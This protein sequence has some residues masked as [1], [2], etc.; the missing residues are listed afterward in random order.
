MKHVKRAISLFLALVLALALAVPAMAANTLPSLSRSNYIK[1]Y[2]IKS[3]GKIY[4]YTDQSLRTQKS[5]WIG[6]SYD[7]CRIVNISGDAVQVLYPLDTGGWISQPQWFKRSDFTAT[8]ISGAITYETITKQITTYRRADGKQQYGY[9]GQN[10]KV[11]I[12]GS[13]GSYTQIIYPLTGG[14][15]KMAWAKTSELNNARQTNWNSGSN[16]FNPVWPCASAYKITCMYYYK[17]GTRHSTRYGYQNAMDITGGGNILAV[18]SGKVESVT[19]SSTGFGKHI[20][21]LHPN[22]MRTLYAHLS[23]FKVSQGQQVSKG[24]VIGVMGS[25]GNSSGTHLHFE[26]SSC[27]PWKTYYRN[28][29][30]NKISFEQNV[31]SNNMNYNSDK[32]IV[33]W[34]DAYYKKSGTYYVC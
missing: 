30:M 10:D 14:N 26:M 20:V 34:I 11:Y 27:D 32:T 12:L 16:S 4:A 18:E 1:T 8:S 15:W 17:D 29:Y 2:T 7:E 23:S 9:I 33:N 22:G 19:N 6:C 3:S 31:R 24:Q 13:S 5:N 25:T 21:I 28:A